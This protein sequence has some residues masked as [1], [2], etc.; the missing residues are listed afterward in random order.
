MYP[1]DSGEPFSL[2]DNPNDPNRMQLLCRTCAIMHHEYWDDMWQE[3]YSG[4]L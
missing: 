2:K 3:Y 1:Y 4:R